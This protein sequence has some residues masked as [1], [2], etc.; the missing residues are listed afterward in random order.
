MTELVIWRKSLIVVIPIQMGTAV[1][2]AIVLGYVTAGSYL[3]PRSNVQLFHQLK[4]KSVGTVKARIIRSGERGVL[5]LN[6]ESHDIDF[7][8]WDSIERMSTPSRFGSN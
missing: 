5:Y 4:I 3:N 2:V 1:I 7:V 8:K 6:M